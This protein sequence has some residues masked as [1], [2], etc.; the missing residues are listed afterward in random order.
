MHE[1]LLQLREF[2]LSPN[3]QGIYSTGRKKKQNTTENQQYIKKYTNNKKY[4]T[5][6]YCGSI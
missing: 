6:A 3:L 1:A 4:I 5:H 2:L